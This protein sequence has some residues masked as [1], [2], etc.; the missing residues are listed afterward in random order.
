MSKKLENPALISRIIIAL[1]LIAFLAIT[2]RF[3][4]TARSEQQFTFL[5]KSFLH[6]R[7]DFLQPPDGVWDD[8]TPQGDRYYWPL[9]PAPAVLLM[10]FELVSSWFGKTFYSGYLQFGLVVAALVII[11]GVVRR[12]GYDRTDATYAAFGF[13][14]STAFL[15]V[16]FWPW[17]WYLAHVVTCVAC[18][19]AILE[20]LGKRRPWLIGTMFAVCLATR[21]T[22]AL[23]LLWFVGEVALAPGRTKA[24]KVRSIGIAALPGVVTLALLLLYNYARF[25][26]PFEQGYADQ[27]IPESA[28]RAR[29]SG[30]FGLRHAPGNLYALLLA[31][32]VPILSGGGLTMLKPP[33]VAANPWGMSIFVTSPWFVRLLSFR[34]NDRSSRLIWA[35]VI[36]IAVPVLCYYAVGYRQFGY[37]YS[38][39]FLPFLFYLL[40]RHYRAQREK[41]SVS[42]KAVIVVCAIWNLNLFLGHYLWRLT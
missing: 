42:F 11:F 16:A 23:G 22:A 25:G 2:F 40:L 21:A 8:T 29:D 3:D 38:L 18:F 10:P 28:A 35:T 36:I 37:R 41:L 30:I 9:G 32:P 12:I 7:L 26:S 20:M 6:G 5:A 4:T 33:F 13:C 19:G 1:A 27:I 34:Y 17:S 24:E 15:G 39:D 14:F 31:S